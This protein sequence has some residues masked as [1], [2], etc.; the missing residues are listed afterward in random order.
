MSKEKNVEAP[1][2]DKQKE[3]ELIAKA[4]KEINDILTRDK[5]MLVPTLQMIGQDIQHSVHVAAQPKESK[6]IKPE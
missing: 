6:I 3:E 2:T 1:L 4:T 5:L